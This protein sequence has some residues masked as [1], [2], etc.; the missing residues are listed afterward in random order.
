MIFNESKYNPLPEIKKLITTK[1][2]GLYTMKDMDFFKKELFKGGV[3]PEDEEEFNKVLTVMAEME[4][5]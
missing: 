1:G 2:N 4:I 3:V 5:I